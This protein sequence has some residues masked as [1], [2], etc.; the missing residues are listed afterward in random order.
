MTTKE[1]KVP[2][3]GGSRVVIYL[4]DVT[5]QEVGTL[6]EAVADLCVERGVAAFREDDSLRCVVTVEP[7]EWPATAEEFVAAAGATAAQLILPA[8]PEEAES[9]G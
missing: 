8:E 5:E 7:Y 2:D 9:N 6:A 1:N 4:D 3:R